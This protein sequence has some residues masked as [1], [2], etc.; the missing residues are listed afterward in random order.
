LTR[1]VVRIAYCAECGYED[2]ALAVARE[3]LIDVGQSLSSVTL[4]PFGDG[5]FEVSVDGRLVH[6]MARDG[7]FPDPGTMSA[8]VRAK[9]APAAEEA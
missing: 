4:I 2:Q 6:S 3:L 1:P 7:G 9:L 5:T 8:A